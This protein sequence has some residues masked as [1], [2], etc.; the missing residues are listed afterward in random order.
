[1]IWDLALTVNTYELFR[2]YNIPN[3]LGSIRTKL[4]EIIK[5]TAYFRRNLATHMF[6]MMVC[7]ET[8]RKKSYALPLQCL[9]YC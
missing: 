8:C 7:S 5:R 2:D 6:V 1:M 9:P 3:E 4:C